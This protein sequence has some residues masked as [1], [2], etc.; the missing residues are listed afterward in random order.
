MKKKYNF[1]YFGRAITASQ[2]L[3]NVPENWEDEVNEFGEYSWGGYRA[4]E[5]D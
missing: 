2:F 1:Y 4:I 3:N 5:R